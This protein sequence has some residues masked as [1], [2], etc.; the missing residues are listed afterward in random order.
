MKLVQARS[1]GFLAS[2]SSFEFPVIY[3]SCSGCPRPVMFTAA[4]A[5]ASD[6]RVFRGIGRHSARQELPADFSVVGR[7]L[8]IEM[9]TG[10]S[11]GWRRRARRGRH[12]WDRPR[13]DK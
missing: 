8:G 11:G 2:V 3:L 5:A 1:N 10:R 4:V 6:E 7:V 13:E 12:P 9:Q